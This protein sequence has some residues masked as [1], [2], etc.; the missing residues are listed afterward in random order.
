[1]NRGDRREPIFKEDAD[2]PR[3]IATLSEACAK[4]GWQVHA[5]VLMPNLHLVVATP[6][7]NLVASMKWL[8]RESGIPKDSPA[9][10]QQLARALE[11]R[12]GVQRILAEEW[13]RRKWQASDLRASVKGIRRRWRWR[14]AC[15]RRRRRQDGLRND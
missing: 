12:R 14:R 1:M 15:G 8:L 9:E 4:N 13:K 10:R 2:R 3:L 5:Y 7:P 11:A 6:Q